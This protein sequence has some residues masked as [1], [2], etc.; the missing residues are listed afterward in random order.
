LLSP[1][2]QSPPKFFSYRG[3]IAFHRRH[4][5]CFIE[6]PLQPTTIHGSKAS[7]DIGRRYIPAP[8]TAAQS[9]TPAHLHEDDALSDPC[10]S[11]LRIGVQF[12]VPFH[13]G[14]HTGILR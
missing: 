14:N 6:G 3:T 10:R 8:Q 13:P 5:I 9:F 1:V 7:L 2:H 11:S 12:E 4:G